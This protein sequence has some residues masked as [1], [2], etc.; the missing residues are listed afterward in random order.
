MTYE[1]VRVIVNEPPGGFDT[2]EREDTETISHR[3]TEAQ[4]IER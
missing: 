2:E 3:D 4:R 1:R